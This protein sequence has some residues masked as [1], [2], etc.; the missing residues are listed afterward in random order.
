MQQD[1]GSGGKEG[2]GGLGR[3]PEPGGEGGSRGQLSSSN[4]S[5]RGRGKLRGARADYDL[6]LELAEKDYELK[7]AVSFSGINSQD[8]I[9]IRQ[10]AFKNEDKF[11]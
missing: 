5:Q 2:S 4:K 8:I 1:R 11:I 7:D 6:D 10:V 9:V 3:G